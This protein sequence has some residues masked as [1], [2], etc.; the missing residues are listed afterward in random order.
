M[1]D[2]THHDSDFPCSRLDV[3]VRRWL[4]AHSARLQWMPPWLG[5][6]ISIPTSTLLFWCL[7][8]FFV[9]PS[10]GNLKAVILFAC[11][12]LLFPGTVALLNF[13][14]NRLMAQLSRG[15]SAA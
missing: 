9:D 4:R 11:V 15:R 12:G 14:S 6:A 5:V 7:A 3:P 8:L 1:Q 2:S 13:E 10:A